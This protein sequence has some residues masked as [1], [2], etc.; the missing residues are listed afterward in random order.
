MKLL[1]LFML[2]FSYSA[3][4]LENKVGAGM[5]IGN[6]TGVNAKYWLDANKAIDAG[7]GFSFGRKT[8]LSIHSDYLLHQKAVLF[9]N[10]IHPL[11]L[12]YGVG[13]RM[14]FS[15]GLEMGVRIPV[16]LTHFIE[17]RN[18]DLFVEVAPLLDFISKIGIELHFALG[19]RYYF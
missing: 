13:G 1:V 6:P 3:F 8:E 11:D 9:Y 17:E 12:Y 15:D 19:A 2:F 10:D 5:M 14:E 18:A 7:V 16:G 4:S